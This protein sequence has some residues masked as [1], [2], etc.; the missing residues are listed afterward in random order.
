MHTARLSLPPN[1]RLL[2]KL[3]VL[4]PNTHAPESHFRR[5]AGMLLF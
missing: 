1:P 4:D 5:S 3:L 2:Q